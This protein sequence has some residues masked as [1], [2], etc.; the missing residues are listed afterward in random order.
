MAVR[1]RG[2]KAAS[3]DPLL[4][5]AMAEDEASLDAARVRAIEARERQVEPL[6]KQPTK[7]RQALKAALA[8]PPAGTKSE[9][10]KARTESRACARV[11]LRVCCGGWRP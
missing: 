8:D 3:P 10:I 6:L 9:A 5:L 4:A 2:G 11:M 7:L 1:T